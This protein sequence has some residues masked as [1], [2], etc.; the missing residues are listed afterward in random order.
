MWSNSQPSTA[1][2]KLSRQGEEATRILGTGV[3]AKQ[4]QIWNRNEL[5]IQT[6]TVPTKTQLSNFLG[7]PGEDY[8]K[9]NPKSLNFYFLVIWWGKDIHRYTSYP[10]LPD[11][12]ILQIPCEDRCVGPPKGR[13]SGG[14]CGSKPPIHKVFGRLGTYHPNQNPQHVLM[15]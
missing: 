7:T 9:G 1:L 13:T 15:T 12:N 14:V 6:D 2:P 10:S 11:S 3:I 8:F 4:P 5:Q